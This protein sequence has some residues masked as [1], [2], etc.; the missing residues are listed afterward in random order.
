MLDRLGL[1]NLPFPLGLSRHDLCLLC[2]RPGNRGTGL[3]SFGRLRKPLGIAVRKYILNGRRTTS[4][5]WL[6][7]SLFLSSPLHT[8]KTQ[9]NLT[10]L[11]VNLQN[12]HL[13]LLINV[14]NVLRFV[15]LMVRKL[16]YVQQTF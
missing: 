5:N 14:N 15:N 9:T 8:T 12:L 13:D 1:G 4:P 10:R 3:G 6:L 2:T 7:L 16:G 11:A